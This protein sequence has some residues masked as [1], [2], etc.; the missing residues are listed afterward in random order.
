MFLLKH[1]SLSSGKF[2]DMFGIKDFNAVNTINFQ[3]YEYTL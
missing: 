2:K 3:L 1:F